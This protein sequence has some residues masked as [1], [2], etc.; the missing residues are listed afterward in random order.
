M[1][2]S[3]PSDGDVD[4]LD[5]PGPADLPDADGAPTPDLRGPEVGFTDEPAHQRTD[6]ARTY[7]VPLA[8]AAGFLSDA[9]SSD[10]SAEDRRTLRQRLADAQEQVRPWS[11]WTLRAK[12]VASMLVLFSLIGIATGTF[13]VLALSRQLTSQVDEQL[14]NSMVRQLADPQGVDF[15]TRRDEHGPRGPG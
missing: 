15:G 14:R 2:S 13:T 12:L 4:R 5:R 8:P 6:D 7:A 3:R 10:E 9:D 11:A 1:S